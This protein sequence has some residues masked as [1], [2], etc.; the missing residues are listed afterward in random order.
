MT[1]LGKSDG[2]A[3]GGGWRDITAYM[4]S[5]ARFLR[6]FLFDRMGWRD[7]YER[8]EADKWKTRIHI[9]V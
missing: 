3:R 5:K 6:G 9:R 4:W 8:Y 1:S 2:G 7:V